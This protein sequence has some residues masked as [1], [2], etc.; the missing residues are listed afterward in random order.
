MS[1]PLAE[2]GVIGAFDNRESRID[3][4]QRQVEQ[5]RTRRESSAIRTSVLNGR[6]FSIG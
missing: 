5:R 4:G 1:W 3:A 2:G 6:N